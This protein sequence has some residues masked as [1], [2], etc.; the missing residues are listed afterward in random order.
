V[1]TGTVLCVLLALAAD[2][3]LLLLGRVLTPWT[4]RP[5]S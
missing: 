2:L 1:V 4:R 5:A 3:A